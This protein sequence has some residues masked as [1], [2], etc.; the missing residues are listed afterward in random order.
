MDPLR[1]EL[2]F[3]LDGGRAHLRVLDALTGFRPEQRGERP[4]GCD[5]SPWQ[6]VE[7]MRL[8]QRDILSYCTS[9]RY[10][11]LAFPDGYWPRRPA[12]PNARAWARSVAG[13]RADL[14][15]LCSVVKD[16]RVD[17]LA[18]IPRIGVSWLHELGIVA[19][20]NSYHAGQLLQL[21]KMMAAS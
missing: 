1:T 17:L 13:F 15:Q 6:L 11:A 4:P 5:H 21:R 8:A 10:R 2:L 14:K 20:H 16:P 19:N 9:A 12:P 7:H 3:L 18:P